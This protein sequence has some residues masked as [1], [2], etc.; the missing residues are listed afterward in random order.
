M[1][2]RAS[3]FAGTSSDRATESYGNR[4]EYPAIDTATPAATPVL[5]TTVAPTPSA[6]PTLTP[7]PAAT[8]KQT[9]TPAEA[10]SDAIDYRPYLGKF[11]ANFGPF[12][13]AEFTVLVQKNHL[14][15]DVPG[16]TVYELKDPDEEGMWYLDASD[17]IAVSFER[18]DSGD[19]TTLKQHRSGRTFKLPRV[20]VEVPVE[21][22]LDELHKYLGS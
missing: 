3:S 15:I 6:T 20:G 8:V 18:D 13:D 2:W 16:Q 14:A 11:V 12:K 17:A 1:R 10:E 21:I 5:P 19:V 4:R 7:T 22:P 9:A